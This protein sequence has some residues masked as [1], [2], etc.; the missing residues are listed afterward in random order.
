VA[1]VEVIGAKAITARFA[2]TEARIALISA[3]IE[4]ELALMW[5]VV[6]PLTPV[7]VT[8]VLRGSWIAD[9]VIQNGTS[10][11]GVLGNP[12]L[13][14]DV[15]EEGRTPGARMPPPDAIAAWVALKLGPDVDPFVV[16]RSIGQKGIEGRRM[17]QKAQSITLS[18]RLAMR[19][20]T[21]RR[22]VE[23]SG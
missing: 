20:S 5:G 2:N 12:Q 18:D 14:A 19:S 22:L 23:E 21:M 15:M 7:G 9:P 4:A 3:E 1:S 8:S 16:A 17:L 13:Y 10:L 6:V 11:I